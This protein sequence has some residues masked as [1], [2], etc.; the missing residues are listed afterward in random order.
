KVLSYT[1]TFAGG[2]CPSEWSLQGSYE[3]GT[4]YPIHVYAAANETHCTDFNNVTYQVQSPGY[5]AYYKW[6]F[7]DGIL[8][9][10]SVANGYVLREVTLQLEEQVQ[11][12]NLMQP[13][14]VGS[15]EEAK[16]RAVGSIADC[17]AAASQLG[18]TS[19]AQMNVSGQQFPGG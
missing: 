2:N 19:D 9:N 6:D 10:A 18:L 5:Y 15:C 7:K 1:F 4:W 12:F 13:S 3:G 8:G 17:T 14:G 11:G 16:L